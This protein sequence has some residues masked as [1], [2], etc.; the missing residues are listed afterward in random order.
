MKIAIPSEN[1]NGL[2]SR[3]SGHFGSAPFF[4]I[5]DAEKD[6]VDF[7]ENHHE[8][9]IHG[10][11]QPTAELS[12]LGV[13]AIVCGGMGIRAINRFHELNIKVYHIGNA[14]AVI[15]VVRM[16][17]SRTLAELTAENAC[18]GHH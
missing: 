7:R 6:A 3:L 2:E 15:D 4:A 12:A 11:C 18:H 16:W 9:H 5:Y 8:E 13:G 10:N 17:K 1:T 14:T